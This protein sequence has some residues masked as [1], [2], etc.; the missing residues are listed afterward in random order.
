MSRDRLIG[1]LG[2]GPVGSILAASY[3]RAGQNVVVV[4]AAPE[5]RRQIEEQGLRVS[6]KEPYVTRDVV[7][8]ESI[9]ALAQHPLDALF[10]CTKTW[11]L[12]SILPPLKE[13]LG[14]KAL[15]ICWQNGIGA[16]DEVARHFSPT[17]VARGVV[18]YAGEV[19]ED[20]TAKQ[21]WFNP[22][23]YLGPL[24]EGAAP[25]L[26]ELSALL[27]KAGLQTRTVTLHEVKK[28][29]FYKTILNA[30]LS[31]LCAITGITMQKA[32]TYPPTRLMARTAIQEGLT[33]AAAAGYHYGE[34]AVEISMG[35]L[36]KGGDHMPS[37]WVDLQREAPTEIEYIN[38]KIIEVGEMFKHLDVAIN[39]FF[40]AAIVTA[41]IKSG[42]RDAID[43]PRYL[44]DV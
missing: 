18:N 4:E 13:A 11:S 6:G 17:R 12:K 44:R 1:V 42:V 35:Y 43:V 26:E 10:L 36:E 39:T 20:G 8:V 28:M 22:P 40:A 2:A 5:R 19:E 37:M 30:S 16:E 38:C 7:V 14:P 21:I 31:P 9:S 41:E 32:M 23:N 25:A 29:A 27:S 34:D 33:V 3:A 24:D 15:V